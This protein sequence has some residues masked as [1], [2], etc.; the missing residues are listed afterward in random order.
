LRNLLYA[1]S[2]VSTKLVRALQAV[3]EQKAKTKES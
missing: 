1:L 2:G 3:A